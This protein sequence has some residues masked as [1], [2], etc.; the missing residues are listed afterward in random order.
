MNIDDSDLDVAQQKSPYSPKSP[1]SPKSPCS[2]RKFS[3]PGRDLDGKTWEI[4]GNLWMKMGK[5]SNY[6]QGLEVPPGVSR[7][8]RPGSR[9]RQLDSLPCSWSDWDFSLRCAVGASG[10]FAP[11]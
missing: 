4:H 5:P 2:P 7:G 9:V 10:P 8:N 6:R 1:W 3:L 11:S